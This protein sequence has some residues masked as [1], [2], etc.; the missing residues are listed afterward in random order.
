MKK[1]IIL[2]L[3]LCVGLL[4]STKVKAEDTK[5]HN[6]LDMR[7]IGY[8]EEADI[9]Y[10]TQ[11]IPLKRGAVYTLVASRDFF[12]DLTKD[13]RFAL[14][15]KQIGTIFKDENNDLVEL[16]L[17]VNSS[18][19]GLY[20]ATIVPNRNCNLQITDFLTKGY[21]LDTLPRNEIILFEGE[22]ESFKGFKK[23]EFMDDYHK[24]EQSF[25]IYTSYSNPI[26]IEDISSKIKVYDNVDGFSDNFTIVT[27]EYQC[28]NKLGTYSII[29]TC[30]DS[31]N[32]EV[33]LKV[34]VIVVDEIPP[35]IS[36]PDIFEWDCYSNAP[37]ESDILSAYSAVDDLDGDLSNQIEVIDLDTI[38][39]SLG[40]KTDYEVTLRVKDYSGNESIKKVT[41]SAKD[42]TPPEVEVADIYIKLSDYGKVVFKDFY[43]QVIVSYSD[44][45]GYAV[46]SYFV[47]E[48]VGKV[49]F[50]GEFL[51]TVKILDLSS[52]YTQKQARIFIVDD[53]APEFYLHTDLI[54]TD[55]DKVYSL[56]DIKSVIGDKLTQD[57]ILY[58]DITLI[59]CDYFSNEK[60][61]G[62]Y[63]VKYMYS[64]NGEA[65]YMVGTIRV[66]KEESKSY[67]W[68]LLLLI[69]PVAGVGVYFSRRR[70]HL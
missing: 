65:N 60:K 28:S 5:Y 22:K 45:S 49:G 51:I 2:I 63:S 33:T 59:S 57:G 67:S 69:I 24:L 38:N 26:K 17:T 54:N 31:S 70:K 64:Y 6:L 20:D 52:N 55:V 44:N 21:N 30:K 53:L 7:Q 14:Q 4:F 18:Q 34:N 46:K 68:L 19:T 58:D 23:N 41:I 47:E 8:N 43:S 61:S 12:G 48:L 62:N 37:N 50:T 3:L 56:E 42:I 9:F 40:N 13:D 15:G 39:Y 16:Y 36:G 10:S 11:K 66:G 27:D 35:V 1:I 25:N 32:V 29:Y